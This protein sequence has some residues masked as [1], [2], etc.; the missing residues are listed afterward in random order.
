MEDKLKTSVV[1][2]YSS[3]MFIACNTLYCRLSSRKGIWPVN[4]CWYVGGGDVTRS[5]AHIHV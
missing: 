2:V 1:L 4:E 3:F 5:F